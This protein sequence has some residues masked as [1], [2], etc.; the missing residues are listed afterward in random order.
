VDAQSANQAL[1]QNNSMIKR[2]LIET[3]EG[4]ILGFD[5]A[6]YAQKLG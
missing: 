1:L 4:I 3:K 5:E 6:E 2:P